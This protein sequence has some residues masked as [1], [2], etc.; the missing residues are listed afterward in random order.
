M[1]RL[2]TLAI[3][4]GLASAAISGTAQNTTP[5]IHAVPIQRTSSTSG[6]EMYSSYCAACHGATATGNGPAAQALKVPP[7]DLTALSKNNHG[8]FPADHVRAVLQFGA[9]TPAHGSAGMPVW[10]SV[11]R[12]LHTTESNPNTLVN[13][14]IMNLTNY[15]KQLQK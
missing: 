4:A 14:R 11:L 8:V 7:T 1:P 10:G 5:K 12:T 15:L 2:V 3:I 9:T 13:L 6:L